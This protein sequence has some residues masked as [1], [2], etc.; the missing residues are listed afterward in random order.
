M[1]VAVSTENVNVMR[2]GLGHIAVNQFV[3]LNRATCWDVEMAEDVL[4]QIDAF[5][6]T[7]LLDKIVNPTIALVRA[8][9]EWKMTNVLI[10][11]LT[12]TAARF[13]SIFFEKLLTL[14]S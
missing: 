9:P 4:D 10:N 12:I 6:F 14:Y 13:V 11:L 3:E 2:G 1:V 7:D 5:V 8:L